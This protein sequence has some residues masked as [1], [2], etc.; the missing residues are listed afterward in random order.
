VTAVFEALADAGC[1]QKLSERT[2]QSWFS[3]STVVPKLDKVKVL[4]AFANDAIRV[5]GPNRTSAPQLPYGT[6]STLIH[7]GLVRTLTAP[8]QAKKLLPTLLARALEYEPLSPL[9]LHLDAIEIGALTEGV[10]DIPWATVKALGAERVLDI[11][12]TRWSPRHGTLYSK[13][14]SEMA[15]K[16]QSATEEERRSIQTSWARFKPDLFQHFMDQAP[17]P[18]WDKVGAMADIPGAH[19]HKAL[20]AIGADSRFLVADRLSAWSL[21]LATAA[22]AMHARAWADRYETFGG[23]RVTEEMTYWGA[24]VSLLFEDEEPSFDRFDL[25]PA[26]A[27]SPAEWGADSNRTLL[28]GRKT[29]REALA[30]LGTSAPEVLAIAMQGTEAHP[31]VYTG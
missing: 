20:F 19:I 15:L 14:S 2:W 1:E 25:L 12:A 30:E 24:F 5:P 10:G 7:G 28:L 26:M 3:K 18:E 16:W 6:F 23:V 31:L 22:L 21:D 8:S 9:H 4:D 13:L 29:Y 27:I 17:A 11:L